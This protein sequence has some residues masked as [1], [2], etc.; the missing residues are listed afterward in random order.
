MVFLKHETE[1]EINHQLDDWSLEN[2]NSI[3]LEIVLTI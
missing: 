1:T 2:V 3:Y